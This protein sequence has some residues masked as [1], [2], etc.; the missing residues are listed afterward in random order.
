LRCMRAP[1]QLANKRRRTI[2]EKHPAKSRV[3]STR[4]FSRATC[5]NNVWTLLPS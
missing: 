4:P 2:R 1:M 5:E 3:S